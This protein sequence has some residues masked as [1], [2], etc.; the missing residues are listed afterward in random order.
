MHRNSD[1]SLLNRF[2]NYST[3]YSNG[4]THICMLP[5]K[6]SYYI[7]YDK[8]DDMLED[9]C[10]HFQ[11][12][13]DASLGIGEN[14]DGACPILADIDMKIPY[15][16]DK[17]I[18]ALYSLDDVKT[19]VRIY[20][21][22]LDKLFSNK[23]DKEYY[24]C[25]FL[26]KDPYLTD[27]GKFVKHGFH[28]H[29]PHLFLSV[30]DQQNHIIPVIEEKVNYHFEQSYGVKDVYDSHAII[31]NSW[32]LYKSKKNEYS[33]TYTVHAIF[34]SEMNEIG[35]DCFQ[36]Y[37]L[38]DKNGDEIQKTHDI[39][40]YLP[41][42]LSIIPYGRKIT[43]VPIQ[44]LE[45]Y[46]VQKIT[47][48]RNI[49]NN[50]NVEDVDELT[51]EQY[52]ANI[53]TVKKILPM[54]SASRAEHHNTRIYV[55]WALYN[56][57]GPSR[58][59]LEMWMEWVSQFHGSAKDQ[60]CINQWAKM[61]RRNMGM[62]TL[63]HMASQDSPEQYAIYRF[64]QNKGQ[65]WK[66]L[67]GAHFDLAELLYHDYKDYFR[68]AGLK[69]KTWY[70]FENHVWRYSEEGIDLR[71]KI[72]GELVVRF[73]SALRDMRRKIAE[74]QTSDDN[75]D[76]EFGFM[77]ADLTNIRAKN[78]SAEIKLYS[79]RIDM[80]TKLITKL[81]SSN[82]KSSV[83][84]ECAGLFYDRE[85]ED[86]LNMNPNLIAFQNGIYDLEKKE[87]RPGEPNDY[88][89]KKMP[90]DFEEYDHY[91][92]EVIQVYNFFE[93]IFPDVSVREYF[94]DTMAGIFHGGNREKKF[95]ILTGD[96]GNN[97][98]SVTINMFVKMLGKG[99]YFAKAPTTL[100][101]GKKA[102]STSADPMKSRTGGGIRMVVMDEPSNNEEINIGELK[103]LTGNDDFPARDLFQAGKEMK[104]IK[105][106]FKLFLVS[107]EPPSITRG[108]N[109]FW[110]R[111]RIIPFES[112]FYT[113]KRDVP[114][115]P[116]EQQRQKKFLAD[117][118]FEEKVLPNLLQPLAWLLLDRYRKIR[119]KRR[120]EPAKVLEAT[121]N[122]QARN[123]L[124]SEY[125][126]DTVEDAERDDFISIREL[127]PSFKQW[128]KENS[129]LSANSLPN[130]KE[131]EAKLNQMWKPCNAQKEWQG[132]K[133]KGLD[134]LEGDMVL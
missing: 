50:Y 63:M 37:I 125:L 112:V 11:K 96:Q 95:Y 19:V 6:D 5:K 89:S 32:L 87:L 25:V 134:G 24:K 86:K 15:K 9:Y 79:K 31:K 108:D 91:S 59:V 115:S 120:R 54:I 124:I 131:F 65:I 43:Q 64:N 40:Y 62:G 53:E 33:N 56:V 46:R 55:G 23:L 1:Y 60:S 106:L 29:F 36:D 99:Q 3:K 110:N 42:I 57:C 75:D 111:T 102:S 39:E 4:Y 61:K 67:S 48:A 8:I 98:K 35:I 100:I 10:A 70:I 119:G 71:N 93:K 14:I 17:E 83:M 12:Q 38:Y 126:L 45:S 78:K 20:H 94:L 121:K 116:E 51:D 58:E 127:Y 21:K 105:P 117:L 49:I 85:F 66:A 97:G 103:N 73:E 74:I 92:P 41:R 52:R 7:E 90:I 34:D 30:A 13:P 26:R 44:P 27:D 16:K 2:R 69:T 109:A 132:K 130:R 118:D 114:E 101:T 18:E 123:D 47:Q 76:E 84:T 104:E 28:L 80:I 68:C 129:G 22:L 72:S 88:I 81:K 128:F 133:F 122:Y 77:E 82:F 107:N 113:D